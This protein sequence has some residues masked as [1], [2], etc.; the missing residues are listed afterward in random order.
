MAYENRLSIPK[1]FH[2]EPV[3][4]DEVGLQ[5]LLHATANRAAEALQVVEDY[6]HFILQ[7]HHLTQFCQALRYELAQTAA[8]PPLGENLYTCETAAD[9]NT[10]INLPATQKHAD[11][12]D[13]CLV[14]LECVSQALRSLEEYSNIFSRGLA[15]RFKSL[16]YQCYTLRQGAQATS[17]GLVRLEKTQLYVLVTGCHKEASFVTLIRQLLRADVQAIQLRDKSLSDKILLQQAH[18]L[19][20]LTRPTDTLAIIND[21]P[22]IAQISHADGVHVGQDELSIKDVRSVVGTQMLVG[23]STHSIEQARAA[24]LDGA[25][26]I[27]VG[28]TFASFTKRFDHYPGLRLLQAVQREIRLPAFA[29]GGINRTNL[30]QIL[31]VG[32]RRVAV[33]SA[34]IA[35][36]NPAAAARELGTQ[37]RKSPDHSSA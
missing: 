37:L 30:P 28:P 18:L 25:S 16:R 20:E 34:V 9:V 5:R 2:H 31:D 7:D 10:Q 14:N 33:G 27:G 11:T 1:P 22:D 15:H 24:V 13:T 6:L 36:A 29:I 8:E 3:A 23:L 17:T 32:V 26:Y 35:S 19:C 12:W 4:V 21:R